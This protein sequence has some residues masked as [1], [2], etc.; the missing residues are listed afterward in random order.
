MIY[1]PAF[2]L[3]AKYF[4]TVKKVSFHLTKHAT[5]VVLTASV[6]AGLSFLIINAVLLSMQISSLPLFLRV[7]D[8]NLSLHTTN[9]AKVLLSHYS[10]QRQLQLSV[11]GKDHNI[12][13][14]QSGVKV[15]VDDILDRAK[16]PKG[17]K[18][19]PLFNALALYKNQLPLSYQAD[20]A[21]LTSYIEKISLP[22]RVE[23]VNA[24]IV[25]PGSVDQ[26]AYIQPEKEGAYYNPKALTDQVIYQ[27]KQNQNL[28][29]I[30]D[31]TILEPTIKASQL[32]A[33]FD[34]ANKLLNSKL[35]IK[36]SS[37][38]YKFSAQDL[39][40]IIVITADS[41]GIPQATVS[42]AQLTD[43]LRSISNHFYQT[44][45]NQKV[46]TLDGNII[47]TAT[48]ANGQAI[49]ISSTVQLVSKAIEAGTTEVKVGMSVV[50]PATTY[51]RNY[52]ATSAGLLAYIK[53]FAT[54]HSGSFKVVTVELAG[55]RSAYYNPDISIV[56]ASTYKI[57][58]AYAALKKVE[59]GQLSLGSQ[60][61]S[62][63]LDYCIQRMILVS[64]NTCAYAVLNLIGWAETDNV[65]AAAG[66]DSTSLNN[67]GGGYMSTTARDLTNLLI[68]LYN[69]S[70]IN[71]SNT[72]YLFNLMKEQI[73]RSGIPA[74][75]GGSVVADKVGFLDSWNHDAGIVYAPNTTYVLVILTTN[76]S[77]TTIKELASGLYNIYNQ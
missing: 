62:G 49:N 13:A 30:A 42:Q 41:Q 64:D 28:S 60:T 22:A 59:L 16:N 67:S 27:I 34:R 45:T 11:A 47:S 26:S 38:V 63:S 46:T 20:K 24:S 6:A 35:T 31:P 73:Y 55:N 7:G 44:P 17:W 14:E 2:P 57:F 37:A 12:Q 74:G 9:D 58:L 32:T 66:F 21:K 1:L 53:D 25:I 18:K 48:G 29:I 3:S 68:G 69:G 56:P 70:L 65:I 8:M 43:F 39:R 54:T 72:N 51:L 15:D 4:L 19:V 77:F 36:N 40:K 52:T 71:A 76:S 33:S 75:S 10:Q 5:R 50:P 23:A 61:G